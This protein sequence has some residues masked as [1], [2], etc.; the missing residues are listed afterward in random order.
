MLGGQGQAI[1]LSGDAG[2]GKS[3][4]LAEFHSRAGRSGALVLAGR[5]LEAEARRPFGPFIEA[6]KAA[7]DVAAPPEARSDMLADPDLRFRTLRFFA[8]T[9][10]ALTRK[11]PVLLSIDDLHWADEGTLELFAYLPKALRERTALVIGTYRT[12]DLPEG[13]PLRGAMAELVRARLLTEVALEGLGADGTAQLIRATLELDRDPPRTLVQAVHERCEGNPFYAEEILKALVESGRLSY[14]DGAVRHEGRLDDVLPRSVRETLRARLAR[15]TEPTR[16]ILRL[17]AIIGSSFDFQVLREMT[18]APDEVITAS[19]REALDAQLLEE[20]GAAEPDGFRFRHA[21]TREAVL[22]GL[23]ARERR[24]LHAQVAQLIESGS[25]NVSEGTAEALAYHY[26]EAGIPGKAYEYHLIAGRRAQRLF[27]YAQARRHLGR[28]LDLAP[29]MTDRSELRLSFAKAALQVGDARAAMDAA[30]AAYRG[31]RERGDERGAGMSLSEL[32]AIHMYLGQADQAKPLAEE[33]VRTLEPLGDSAELGEAYWRR[34]QHAYDD[35]VWTNR[36]I[37]IGRR[38]R[39]REVE[40]IGLRFRGV[41]LARAGNSAGLTDLRTALDLALQAGDPKIVF[42][43]RMALLSAMTLLG[44]PPTERWQVFDDLVA[45]ARENDFSTDM[46]LALR[47]EQ[48]IAAGDFDGALRLAAQSS[49]EGVI[50]AEIEMRIALVKVARSGPKAMPDLDEPRRRLMSGLPSWRGFAATSAQVLLL[51]DDARAALEH[52]NVITDQIA[53]GIWAWNHDIAVILGVEAARRVDDKRA[54]DALIALAVHGTQP[55][56]EPRE[57]QARRCYGGADLALR[58][59]DLDGAVRLAGACVGFLAGGQWPFVETLARLRHAELLL[60]RG[61]PG[62]DAAARAD[63]D[64]IVAFW[65]RAR[66]TW[67]LT[68]LAAWAR[69]HGVSRPAVKRLVAPKRGLLTSREREVAGLIAEGLTNRQI[70]GRLVISERTAESHVE[71]IMD[72]FG[73]RTR[74]EIAAKVSA[75]SRA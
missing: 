39:L 51:A 33:A 5:C 1:V 44:R 48:A 22:A 9:I 63:F 10:A 60:Q 66:A 61:G 75:A 41:S 56:V 73:A 70:A 7:P 28:A 57:R 23:L 52:A 20:S 36:M 15:L 6:V 8:S 11:A 64:A 62:D 4:L 49:G 40:S 67:F 53:D 47:V 42:G 43:S 21:L 58:T 3:R 14:G 19:L 74:A 16:A 13:H 54:L 59:G 30:Q 27:A 72:K 55:A 38:L 69:S 45:H 31:F 37:E 71:R 34:A 65:T 32:S 29:D 25:A 24:Q 17:A 18:K 26:D 68:R 12:E 2:I 46:L 35:P 50:R